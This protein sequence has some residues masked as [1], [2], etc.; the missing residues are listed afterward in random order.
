MNI[1]KARE[2]SLKDVS[3]SGRITSVKNNDLVCFESSL[4]RDFIYLMDYNL[5]V[6]KYFEQPLKI[7]YVI[8]GGN[9]YYVPDFLVEYHDGS[10]ELFEVKYVVDLENNSGNCKEKIEIGKEFAKFNDIQFKVITEKEIRREE[11]FNAK[12]L[13]QFIGPKSSSSEENELILLSKIESGVEF[14][15]IDL[16]NSISDDFIRKAELIRSLWRMVA[17]GYFDYNRTKKLTNTT[18]LKL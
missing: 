5:D 12:F 9:R 16:I 18:V 1:K 13:H 4:E 11:L 17:L 3:L 15:F 10:K 2:I 7:D 14:I 8:N 6:K